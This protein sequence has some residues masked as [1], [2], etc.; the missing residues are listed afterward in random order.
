MYNIFM[1]AGAAVGLGS[2]ETV[3]GNGNL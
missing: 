3:E 2:S 1:D